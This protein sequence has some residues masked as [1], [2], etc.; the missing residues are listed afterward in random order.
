LISQIFYELAGWEEV[1]TFKKVKNVEGR[2]YKD[3]HF[4]WKPSA[5]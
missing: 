1:F 3:L 4:V 2:E 5:I